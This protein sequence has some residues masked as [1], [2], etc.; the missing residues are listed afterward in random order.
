MA[1]FYVNMGFIIDKKAEIHPERIALTDLAK[2]R[3]YTY[4]DLKA[5]SDDCA[6]FLVQKRVQRGTAVSILAGNTVESFDIMFAC[7][8]LGCV[9]VPINFRLSAKE[10]DQIVTNA[11]SPLIFYDAAFR[12]RCQ[13]IDLHHVRLIDL[14]KIDFE[15]PKAPEKRRWDYG[16]A[17]D[18]FVLIYTSGTSGEPKGTIQTHGNAFFKSVDSIIDWGMT[19]KDVIL[20]TAPLFHVAGLNALTLSGLHLGARVVLQNRFEAEETLQIIEEEGV[21]C[22]AVVPTALRMMANAPSFATR[23]LKSLRFVPVGGEP[24]D[25]ALQEAYLKKGV[26]VVNVFGLSETTDGAIYQRSGSNLLN[27]SVG[28]PATHVQI[29]LVGPDSQ[30]VGAGE[31]GEVMV[32]GPTVSPGYWRN[33]QKTK[34][35]FAAGWVNTGDL[36]YRDTEGFYYMVGRGDDMIKSGAEKV[37]P[38]EIEKVISSLPAVADVVVIGIPDSKW[39]QVPKAVVAIKKGMKITEDEVIEAIRRELASYKKPKSIVFVDDLPK[40]GSGK[41]DRSLVKKMYA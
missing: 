37:S 17:D 38:G 39:G 1:V 10:V 4:L 35:T 20:V 34:E 14:K 2:R 16:E 18:P 7:A 26:E 13:E 19:Y 30:E 9:F 5:R 31:A 25:A 12:E 15:G 28:K 33:P 24:L 6:D 40:T 22:F 21:T 3:S 36:A 27:G 41:I 8:K 23:E 29:K 32:G 11:Q